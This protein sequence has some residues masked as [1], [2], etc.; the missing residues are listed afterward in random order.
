[1]ERCQKRLMPRM[2]KGRRHDGDRGPL[3]R[4]VHA[5]GT[6]TFTFI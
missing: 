4:L 5:F 6:F 3:L 1:M 2:L